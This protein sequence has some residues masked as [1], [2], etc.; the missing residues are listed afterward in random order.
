MVFIVYNLL[1]VSLIIL[2]GKLSRMNDRQETPE[3]GTTGKMSLSKSVYEKLDQLMNKSPTTVI[4][5]ICALFIVIVLSL[6]IPLY[7]PS[8]SS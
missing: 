3:E 6:T 4:T 2:A 8:K 7:F 5:S 1:S